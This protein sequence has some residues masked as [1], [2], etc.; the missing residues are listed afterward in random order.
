MVGD[1]EQ[2]IGS[3]AEAS[4]VYTF[5]FRARRQVGFYIVK[6]VLPLAMVVAMSWVVFWIDPA[7]AGTQIGVSITTM[8]TLIAYRFAVGAYLPR[9]SYLTR[10]DYFILAST[11]LVFASLIEVVITSKLGKSGRIRAARI[12]DRFAR[13]LFQAAFALV[14]EQ[15]FLL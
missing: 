7:E 14:T 10:M 8:L 13:V 11:V 3:G 1:L 12:I 2:A 4:P 15:A 9:V 6:I 5:S